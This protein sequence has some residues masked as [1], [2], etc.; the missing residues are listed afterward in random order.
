MTTVER[1]VGPRSSRELRGGG[2]PAGYGRAGTGRT[3]DDVRRRGRE[4]FAA[5]RGAAALALDPT[6]DEGIRGRAGTVG[7]TSTS[8]RAA[9][10]GGRSDRVG[11]TTAGALAEALPSRARP[12]RVG[13]GPDDL[14][15]ARLAA[16]V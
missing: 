12:G 4:A 13:A 11:A 9:T 3:I 15:A 1:K 8:G 10:V 7:S 2:E 5:T 16:A 14:G 6:L